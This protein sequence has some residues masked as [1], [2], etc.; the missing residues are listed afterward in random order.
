MLNANPTNRAQGDGNY[1]QNIGAGFTADEI[2]K[3]IT[4]SMYD[5]EINF[6]PGPYGA[7][8]ID[9]TNFAAWGHYSQIVWTSTLSVGCFTQDCT[10][11]GGLQGT[12]D[13]RV[14]PLFTVCNYYPSG[15]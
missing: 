10:Q 2:P 7:D 12:G 13:P 6:Y 11:Q 9:M 8:T 4:N 1:G 5:N 14:R 15:E 3:M